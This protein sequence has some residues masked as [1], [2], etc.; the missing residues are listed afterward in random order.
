MTSP[1]RHQVPL[2]TGI[3]GDVFYNSAYI[4]VLPQDIIQELYSSIGLALHPIVPGSHPEVPVLLPNDAIVKRALEAFDRNST[5]D[6]H[7]IG[8]IYIG[9]G[10]TQEAEILANAVGSSAYAEFVSQLGTLVRLKDAIM[11]TQGLDRTSDIDGRHAICWRD[12]STEVVFHVTTMMPTNLE[13]DAPCMRKKAHIGNDFVNIIWN[14]SGSDFSFQTFPSAFNY[15]YIVITPEVRTSFV[16]QRT[17]PDGSTNETPKT[18]Q[19]S[20]STPANEYPLITPIAQDLPS[21][22]ATLY[23]K[24]QVLSATGFP[25][26]SPAFEPKL[27]SAKALPSFVRLL[28]LN[29]SFFSLVWSNRDGGEHISPWRNRLREIQRLRERYSAPMGPA[30]GQDT[31][32]NSAPPSAGLTARNFANPGG[33]GVPLGT[34]GRSQRA[35]A[36]FGAPVDGGF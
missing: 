26:I 25:P 27:V 33:L 18:T 17:H 32:N 13:N 9:E 5:V 23:Y 3:E 6:G 8:V 29:A 14:D 10:Q 34:G 24:I 7:R 15:V 4:G 31:P 19:T 30:G 21:P 22:T 11:N 28:A 36:T 1:P 35:S 16:S 12:R 2:T 20:N